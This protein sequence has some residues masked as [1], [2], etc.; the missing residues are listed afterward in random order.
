VKVAWTDKAVAQLV[1]IHAQI[2]ITS[3]RYADR[4]VD[5]ITRRT[6]RLETMPG[7]GSVVP[8]YADEDIR[9]VLE[10]PYRIIY[11]VLPDGVDVLAVVHAARLLPPLT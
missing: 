4:M 10:R 7:S 2:A 3:A 6:E 8:E 11:R 5:R 9:K 1:A